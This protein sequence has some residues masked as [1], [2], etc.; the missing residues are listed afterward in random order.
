MQSELDTII[1]HISNSINKL[2]ISKI[3]DLPKWINFLEYMMDTLNIKD[4]CRKTYI[5]L[6]M[7]DI[8]ILSYIWLNVVPASPFNV[9]FEMII[10]MIEEK[11][12]TYG[13]FHLA[14]SRFAFREQY[15]DESIENYCQTIRRLIKFNC[16]PDANKILLYRFITGITSLEVRE[17][18][19]AVPNLTLYNAVI[20]ALDI[21][22]KLVDSSIKNLI[23]EE[24]NMNLLNELETEE[25]T[26]NRESSII[27]DIRGK[28]IE[29]LLIL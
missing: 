10:Y 3:T 7:I 11:Y 20:T 24:K 6:R 29:N 13:K 12:L 28:F 23:S 22:S 27:D 17:L 25:R 5:L 4:N 14:N 26:L 1:Q 19:S 8:P 15:A 21:E 18:L 16:G 9:P 2:T